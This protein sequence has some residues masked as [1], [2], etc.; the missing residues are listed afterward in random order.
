MGDSLLI[1][2][3]EPYQRQLSCG[4]NVDGCHKIEINTRNKDVFN[5]ALLKLC[6]YSDFL[7]RSAFRY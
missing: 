6:P 1:Q 3:A 7:R 2:F 5:A 4:M